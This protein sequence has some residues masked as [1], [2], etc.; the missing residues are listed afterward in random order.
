MIWERVGYCQ[1]HKQETVFVKLLQSKLFFHE[2]LLTPAE[3]RK[4]GEYSQYVTARPYV[5]V[6]VFWICSQPSD[7]V[8]RVTETEKNNSGL[9]D[10]N[11][12]QKLTQADIKALK[13]TGMT[14]NAIVDAL[15]SNSA[16]FSAKTEFAQDKYKKKK[17]K[18][19]CTYITLRK[20][21]ARSICQVR[22]ILLPAGHLLACL[23]PPIPPL[24]PSLNSYAGCLLLDAIK[25]VLVQ[26]FV[27]LKLKP[28]L[29]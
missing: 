11:T 25:Q 6:C 8:T 27:S 29:S 13:E 15:C 7:G 10:D 18:K 22:R 4:V 23:F 2:L 21:T 1:A 3:K 5:F 9:N 17:A 12:N 28:C 26:A 16:T 24:L 20:P 19:Y 14:G